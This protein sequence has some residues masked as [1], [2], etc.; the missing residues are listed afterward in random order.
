M[1]M[2]RIIKVVLDFENGKMDKERAQTMAILHK[3]LIQA[4]GLELDRQKIRLISNRN[5]KRLV[6][7]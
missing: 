1:I 5:P 6:L 7:E 3:Q 2:K 4:Y